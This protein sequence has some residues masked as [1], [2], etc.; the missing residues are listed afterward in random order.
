M[1][2]SY[3]G[4]D[5]LWLVCGTTGAVNDTIESDELLESG[6]GMP[7]VVIQQSDLSGSTADFVTDQLSKMTA[8]DFKRYADEF[9]RLDEAMRQDE[10]GA[11]SG[12]QT[13]RAVA[14]NI[15]AAL[16]NDDEC[17]SLPGNLMGDPSPFDQEDLASLD[18]PLVFV[19][20]HEWASAYFEESVPVVPEYVNRD[21]Y[22]RCRLL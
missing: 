9:I 13:P 10:E 3:S 5:I 12:A 1:D 16:K 15:L 4:R 18:I 22:F 7:L 21:V 17:Y 14:D 19:A 20:R 8:V 6:L 2:G 11:S